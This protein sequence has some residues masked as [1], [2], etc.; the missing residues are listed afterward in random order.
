[1]F[2]VIFKP[3]TGT[4]VQVH[5]LKEGMRNTDVGVCAWQGLLH[6]NLSMVASFLKLYKLVA[7]NNR[8]AL[9]I[10]WLSLVNI[11]GRWSCL[12]YLFLFLFSTLFFLSSFRFTEDWVESTE[13]TLPLPVSCHS[14]VILIINILHWFGRFII[15]D[16]P[17]LLGC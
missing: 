11:K 3:Q 12:N 5:T 15:A 1:M 8:G 7:D 17:I 13:F 6:Q 14:S 16:K 10:W 4:E 9:L 2:T